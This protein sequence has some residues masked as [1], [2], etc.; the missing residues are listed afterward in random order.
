MLAPIFV[1]S[2]VCSS[3]L[4]HQK[5]TLVALSLISNRFLANLCLVPLKSR[6]CVN[7]LGSR[8][9]RDYIESY[10]E[11]YSDANTKYEKMVIIK[12]IYHNL[13]PTCRF[14]RFSKTHG[15]W[16]EVGQA[17]STILSILLLLPLYIILSVPVVGG[18]LIA[19]C[20]DSKC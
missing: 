11:R 12:E 10:R 19:Y 5:R 1:D 4:V 16:E 9:Y 20:L 8:R 6:D 7:H 2:N 15:I 18:G 13:S 3:P 17:M 14:L